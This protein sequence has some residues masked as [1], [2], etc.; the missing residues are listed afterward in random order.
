MTELNWSEQTS[1]KAVRLVADWSV[2]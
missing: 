2:Q 1:G